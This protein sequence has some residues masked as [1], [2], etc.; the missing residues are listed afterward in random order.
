MQ[1]CLK[2]LRIAFLGVKAVLVCY[3]AVSML[4]KHQK[5]WHRIRL[6]PQRTE[7]VDDVV[8]L[9]IAAFFGADDGD[10]VEA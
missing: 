9:H 5:T 7:G 6:Y 3:T 2:S 1:I 8:K 4:K 10:D